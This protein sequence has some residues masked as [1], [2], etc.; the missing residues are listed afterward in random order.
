[1]DFSFSDDEQRFDAE[2]VE[3]LAQERQHPD[4]DVVFAAH[5]ESHSQLASKPQH[6]AFMRRLAQ[7]GWLGMSWPREY[8]GDAHEGLY[9]YLLNERL[10]QAGAPLVGKGIGIIGKT[11]IR[12][13][14]DDL[15]ARFLHRIR[16]AE[17]DFALGYSE[18][19]AGSDLASLKL[20]AKRVD[21]GWELN[22]Q[23]RFSTSAHFADWYWVA[24]RTN[25]DAPKHKGITLFL[26]DLSDPGLTVLEQKTMSDDRT[27]EVFFDA[28][29]VP[30]E[31]VVGEVDKGWTYVCE[32]LDYE[33]YT[34]YTVGALESKMNR[35]ISWA[36]STRRSG[37]PVVDEPEIRSG[38]AE[39]ATDLEVARMLTLRIIDKA[40]RGEVPS[41]EA[42]MCKLTL[43]RLHQKMANWMLD[44][45]GPVGV[46]ASGEPGAADEGRWEHSYRATVIETIGGGSSEIQKNILSRRALGLPT[47]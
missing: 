34:I 17:I 24:A 23:K 5:H 36:K 40:A 3:Y 8:G 25:P 9:E 43:T 44:H 32:A 38:I 35:I 15:R 4:A 29:F 26:V 45:C 12:H 10:S 21:G 1:M 6:K 46:L 27:N 33:R 14:S 39:L 11:I 30:D 22:G 19:D 2:V 16:T 20:R 13:G 37:R 18:P 41:N 7:R 47:L 28:V 31:N 42:S